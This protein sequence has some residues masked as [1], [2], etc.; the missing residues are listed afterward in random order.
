MRNAIGVP[1]PG[2]DRWAESILP[3]MLSANVAVVASIWGADENDVI[4]A[5]ERLA[6]YSG[7]IAW[8]VN[9]SCPNSEHPGSPV[10]HDPERAA[11]VCSAVRSLLPTGVGLWAKLAPD[12]RDVLAVG[13]SCRAAG[14]DAVVVSNTYPAESLDATGLPPLGGGMGGMSGAVLRQYVRPLVEKFADMHPDID[15]IACGGVLSSSDALEYL[16]TGARAVQVG[17]ASLYDPR[18]CHKIATGVVRAMK[19]NGR[20]K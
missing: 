16:R 14:A 20:C 19:E 4:A 2:V 11:E 6:H 3:V 9:L 17:T 10:S 5:A 7:P 8:E 15:V 13:A 12:A 18:A 1:N